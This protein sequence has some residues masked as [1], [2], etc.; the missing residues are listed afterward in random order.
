MYKKIIQTT[1]LITILNTTVA[2]A[3]I[4]RQK[5]IYDSAEEMMAMDEKMNQAIAKHRN[6]YLDEED[7]KFEPTITI[8]D[9]EETQSGYRLIR[10]IPNFNQTDVVVQLEDGI[11]TISTIRKVVEKTESSE[12]ITMS[13]SASSLFIPTDALE[14]QMEQS[15]SNGVLKITLLKK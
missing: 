8:D 11:L 6:L 12:S 15:Y 3:D 5:G 1:T 13:S 4:D 9:F 2:F 10:E 14:N 7:I